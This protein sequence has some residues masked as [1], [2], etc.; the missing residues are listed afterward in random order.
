MTDECTESYRE[1]T[2]ARQERAKAALETREPWETVE[3]LATRANVSK[4]MIDRLSQTA[5]P[6]AV[7]NREIEPAPYDVWSQ[8][9]DDKPK[10]LAVRKALGACSGQ[11]RLY[12]WKHVLPFFKTSDLK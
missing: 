11:E 6:D 3:E 5:P 10:I 4:S 7:C 2:E 9:W 8:E 12:V 1:C